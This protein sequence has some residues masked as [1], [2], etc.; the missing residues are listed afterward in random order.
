MSHRPGGVEIQHRRFGSLGL[1]QIIVM[2]FVYH[3]NYSFALRFWAARYS[4]AD[5]AATLPSPAA[6]IYW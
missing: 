2:H 1:G 3:S 6:L 5:S 4:T